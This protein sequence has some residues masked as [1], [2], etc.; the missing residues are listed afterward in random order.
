MGCVLAS[1][2]MNEMCH[3]Y[4]YKRYLVESILLERCLLNVNG[5]KTSLIFVSTLFYERYL[6][7]QTNSQCM[8]PTFVDK[9]DVRFQKVTFVMLLKPVSVMG[10]QIQNLT[11]K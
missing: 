6:A 11:F 3:R 4:H 9:V 2:Y 10:S 7:L 5:R 1:G 8:E